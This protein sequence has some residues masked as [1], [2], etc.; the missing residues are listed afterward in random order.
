MTVFEKNTEYN[1]D[2]VIYLDIVFLEN[3]C[4]NIIILFATGLVIK[5]KCKIIRIIVASLIRSILCNRE[6]F[7]KQ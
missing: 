1:M 7:I 3:V 4:M 5:H 6:I 2:M